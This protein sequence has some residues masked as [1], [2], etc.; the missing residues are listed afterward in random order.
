MAGAVG[1]PDDFCNLI[2]EERYSHRLTYEGHWEN[3]LYQFFRVTPKVT[4]ELPR[5]FCM[6]G[7]QGVDD[8]PQH[9]AVREAFIDICI[10]GENF[11]N[12]A[13]QQLMNTY[14]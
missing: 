9:N 8:K 13:K 1:R 10:E 7:I 14:L 2:G 4:F 11:L 5:P 12:H 3:N 6:E